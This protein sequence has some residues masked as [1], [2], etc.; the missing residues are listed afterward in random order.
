MMIII[1]NNEQ[2]ENAITIGRIKK[3]RDHKIRKMKKK[4]DAKIKSSN[5]AK[6]S[7]T[8]KK[9]SKAKMRSRKIV[10]L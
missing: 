3:K 10:Y 4:I 1:E 5:K 6:V 9:E 8:K 2:Y 7:H